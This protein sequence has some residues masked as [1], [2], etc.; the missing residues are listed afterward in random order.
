MSSQPKLFEVQKDSPTHKEKLHAFMSANGIETFHS[1]GFTRDELP[2]TAAH[3]KSCREL[4]YGV[5]PDD[6]IGTCFAKVGRLMEEAGYVAYGKT[7]RDA[8]EK[9]CENLRIEKPH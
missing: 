2:W 8:V 1:T 3:M 4:G 6:D 7:E 9:V 5:E